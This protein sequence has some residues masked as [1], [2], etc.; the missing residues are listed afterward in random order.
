MQ[1]WSWELS[2]KDYRLGE[3]SAVSVLMIFVV[4]GVAAIYVRSTRHEHAA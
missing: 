2:F 4:I 1:Y 3:G